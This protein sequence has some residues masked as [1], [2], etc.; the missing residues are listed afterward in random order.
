MET[1]KPLIEQLTQMIK[2]GYDLGKNQLPDIAKEILR[3][4]GWSECLLM[5]EFLGMS[6][7]CGYFSYK[8]YLKTDEVNCEG[9]WIGV[10]LLGLIS[11]GLL[12]GFFASF[13]TFLKI[14]MAPKMYLLETIA[15]YL[16]E[17][18]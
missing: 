3:Y 2:E 1:L 14:K 7:I 9:Y 17:S 5:A 6:L 15:G 8:M 11:G 4:S 10:F 18:K 13:D 12:I 16:K